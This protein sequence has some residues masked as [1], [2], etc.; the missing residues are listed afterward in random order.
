MA[1][2]SAADRAYTDTAVGSL[3][4]VTNLNITG[5]TLANVHLTGHSYGTVANLTATGSITSASNITGLNVVATGDIVASDDVIVG[6]ELRFPDNT[7]QTTAATPTDLTPV[8]TK[9]TLLNANVTAAN[10][11]IA[12]L[13]S[14]LSQTQSDLANVSVAQTA[15]AAT[16]GAAIGALQTDVTA[17]QLS[18]TVLN[19]YNV[20][21]IKA[22]VTAANAAILVNTN[23]VSAANA[24]IAAVA[25]GQTA[26]NVEIQNNADDIATV[27]AGQTA[28]NAAILVNTNRVAAANAAIV[29]NTNRV[30]AANVEIAALRANIT[31]ANAAIASVDL[32]SVNANV[33]AANAAITVNTNRVAAANAAIALVNSNVTTTNGRIDSVEVE[34]ADLRANVD[35]ANTAISVVAAD[36]S[37]AVVDILNIESDVYAANVEII[38]LRANITAA[39]SAIASVDANVTAANAASV[40]NTNRVAAANVE[41]NSLRANITAANA[42]I[43]V[44]T[45][46]VAAANLSIA[47]TNER[48]DELRANITAANAAI[49]VNTNR[50]DAANAA[51]AVLLA[52]TNANAAVQ[53]AQINAI[54]ANVTAANA[55][56]DLKAPLSSPTFTGMITTPSLMVTGTQQVDDQ[57]TVLGN[58]I[59]GNVNVNDSIN[60]ANIAADLIEVTTANVGTLNVTTFN[61]AITGE[62]TGITQVGTLGNL[63]VTSNVT[64][65]NVNAGVVRATSSVIAPTVTATSIGGTLT[66]AAQPNITSLGTLT[67]LTVNGPVNITGSELISTDLYVTGNLYIAGNTTTINSTEVSTGELTVTVAA[68]AAT[69]AATDGAG[70]IVDVSGASI[71]YDYPTDS[72]EVNK[73][74]R[75]LGGVTGTI[76]TASQTNITQ[77]GTLGALTVTGNIVSGNVSGTQ[78]TVGSTLRFPDGTLQT[79]AATTTDVS[80]INANVT[81]ANAAISSLLSNAA[82]QGTQINLVNANVAAANSAISALQ[83][84]AGVQA[85]QIDLINANVSYVQAGITVLTVNAG[86]QSTQISAVNA[87]VTAANSAIST[88][89]SNAASQASDIDGINANVFAANAAIATLSSNATVQA[90]AIDS[91]NA[92]VTA[93]NLSILTNTDRVAAANVEINALRANI[94][95]ANVHISTIDANVAAANA[96]IALLAPIASPSFTG[97]VG[98]PTVSVSGNVSAANLVVGNIASSANITSVNA[99]VGKLDVVGNIQT[100]NLSVT[101]RVSGPLVQTTGNVES[102]SWVTAG[103]VK[104][105]YFHGQLI[106]PNQPYITTVG[107]LGGLNMS[108]NLTGVSWV[109]ASGGGVFDTV[110]GTLQTA[111]QPNITHLGTLDVLGVTG[112]VTTGNVSGATAVFGEI[113]GVVLTNA[114]PYITNVGTLTTLSVTGNVSSAN[115]T[116]GN[117]TASGNISG[118][119]LNL[120]GAFTLGGNSVAA[121]VVTGN[122][123]ASGNISSAQNIIATGNITGDN[124]LMSGTVYAAGISV[125]GGAGTID[126]GSGTLTAGV[127]NADVNAPY[128]N[129]TSGLDSTSSVTGALVVTGGAG[130]SGNVNVG[131]NVAITGNTTASTNLTVI[132]RLTAGESNIGNVGGTNFLF[133]TTNFK[134]STIETENTGMALFTTTVTDLEIGLAASTINLG[135]YSGKTTI[136]NDLE[137][138]GVIYANL[139]NTSPVSNITVFNNLSIRN[140]TITSNL[141]ANAATIGYANVTT[142]LSV[143]NTLASLNAQSGAAT[144]AG[145]LGVLKNINVGVQNSTNANIIVW[146]TTASTNTTNGALQVRGGTGLAGNLNVAGVANVSNVA[147]S[148]TTTNGALIVAGGAGIA[149]DMN[150]GGTV[151]IYGDMIVDGTVTLPQISIAAVNDTPIGDLI[152]STA[153]FTQVALSVRRPLARPALRLDFANN[154]KLDPRITYTRNSPA[155]YTDVTGNVVV[156]DANRPRFTH[157]ANGQPLGL[158]IEESRTNLYTYSTEFDNAAQWDVVASTISSTS[159]IGPDGGVSGLRQLVEDSS[160]GIHGVSAG[161]GLGPILTLTTKYTAS[162]FAKQGTRTQISLIFDGEGTPSIFD[163]QYGNV[164]SEGT[165]Y[166]SSVETFANGWY[167]CSSTVTKTNTSGNVTIALANGGTVVYTGDGTSDAYIYGFDLQQGAFPTTYIPTTATQATREADL[168]YVNGSN[169]GTFYNHTAGSWMVDATVNYRPTDAVPQNQRP[170][171]LSIDDGTDA[172]RIQ[173]VAESKASPQVTRAANLV[174]I[175]GGAIQANIGSTANVTTTDAGKVAV[176]Y[177]TNQIGYSLNGGNVQVDTSATIGTTYN[178]LVIGSGAGTNALN[179]AVSKIMY[180]AKVI[181]TSE[182]QEMSR[183]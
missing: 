163:L 64:T 134:G 100:G 147:Q 29:V 112:N 90:T 118:V 132:G 15:N 157:D 109:L 38:K 136:N 31:A 79:T 62:Q 71:L 152:P 22:N 182:T 35:A 43:V 30:A 5:G 85:T 146:G 181:T 133:G 54:R 138:G 153:V 41:I 94:T 128:A 89:Q 11:R 142:R 8:N 103:D 165:S 117:V 21:G 149:K 96:A 113:A 23:R 88:L 175:T 28:A 17:A 50:V 92:N 127:V 137:V 82:T 172:N 9:I 60:T 80:G 13:S 18:I 162:V 166:R 99:T 144:I 145:G 52:G 130:V 170:T 86:A 154:H 24:A 75:A 53:S 141:I 3:T 84:N 93:A 70:L 63:V 10:A 129:I 126:L 121:N 177:N 91:I 51:I 107:T 114:Q 42:A 120:S 150:V 178:R 124:L 1:A 173:I 102:G 179:G 57:L 105:Q 159:K 176:F 78:V 58:I 72:W 106:D 14:G 108:G 160:N 158:F 110:T 140:S 125:T 156:A 148:T 34:V 48:V 44:N 69:A 46:R 76:L 98:A 7:V 83:S 164:S 135:S 169:F 81:A 45:N 6:N 111:S 27:A 67:G 19:S 167:R 73:N 161:V 55:A 77:V 59:S 168:A 116:T 123:T 61:G 131:G 122:V 95:A 32:T 171:L 151:H 25:A 2:N 183:Q 66:T 37:T 74:I 174:I 47:T 39:N 12:T 139:G 26:A 115:V 68:D 36:L 97:V 33:A 143:D 104:A 155:T 4:A 40:I 16:Q 87:N 20:P 101:G 180:Y 56:I 49:V 119:N 65:A